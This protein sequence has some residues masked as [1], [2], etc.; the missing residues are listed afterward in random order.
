[1]NKKMKLSD[2]L[3]DI[4]TSKAHNGYFCSVEEALT[5][6]ILGTLCGLRNVNQIHQWAVSDMVSE[7]LLKHFGIKDIPCY[8]WLLCLLKIIKPSSLNKCL[9]N[10]V[11]SFLPNG[12]NG[13]TLSFDGKT[14]RSTTKMDK[15]DK[16]LHI[17]SAHIAEL[18]VTL[19]SKKVD[20]K[21]NEIPAMREL[22]ELLNVEGCII[23]ADALHCQKETANTIVK[24]KADYLLNVKS[25]HLTL[26]EDIEDYIQSDE[27]RNNL[28]TA[29]TLEQNSGRIER[30]TSFVCHDI[31]W[32]TGWAG[33]ACIGAIH[34]QFTCKGQTTST[35]NYYISSRT[36]SA[37]QLLKHARMEWAVES[38]HWLLDVH[39]AED[40]CRIEDEQVQQVLNTVRK[41][42]LNT[43]KLYKHESKSMLP[44][45]KIMF[46]S[47]LN[48]QNLL[49]VLNFSQN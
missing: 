37:K 36:L 30:R 13:L 40:S 16:P 32:F 7:F 15:Y 20:D 5:V 49:N 45:S 9:E 19:A 29:E 26:K 3:A 48:C 44:L 41:V 14:V 34:T 23:V 10:W 42:A 39:F 33:L 28:D 2:Y 38:M 31:E 22:I 1:M 6:V 4:E 8:Y 27:L 47:L 25:N 11:Q 24:N 35:W 43:V 18:G 21:S 46:A 17:I 12:V